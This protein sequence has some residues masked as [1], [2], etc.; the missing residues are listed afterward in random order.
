[1]SKLTN[2]ITFSGYKAYTI[3]KINKV[4]LDVIKSKLK[5]KEAMHQYTKMKQRGK[6]DIFCYRKVGRATTKWGA[7]EKRP[8]LLSQYWKNIQVDSVTNIFSSFGAPIIK[9]ICKKICT[10]Y[11]TGIP[12]IET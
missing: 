12:Q 8:I 7:I 1:M 2:S 5:L 9:M 3:T 10:F 4:S 11:D 6:S